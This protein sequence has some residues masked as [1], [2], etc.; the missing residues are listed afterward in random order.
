MRQTGRV[1][2]DHRARKLWLRLERS[3]KKADEVTCQKALITAHESEVK[4][5]FDADSRNP[6]FEYDEEDESHH[7]V[8]FL[9]AVTAYNQMRAASG[10][11]PAGFAVWRLGSEDPSIWSILG[12][13]TVNSPEVL[14]RIVY[15]YDV[16]FEGTGELLQVMS[17][18]QD[19]WRN[20]DI[21]QSTGFVKSEDFVSTPSS[22]VIERGGDHPGLI[23]LTFDDGPDPRWTPAILDILKKEN[24]PA[25]FFIIGKNGQSYP[26]LL[27]RIVNE[28]HEIGNHTFTHPNLGEI[29]VIVN[30]SGVERYS[31]TYR[32]GNWPVDRTVSSAVFWRRRSRQTTGSRAGIPGPATGLPDG[33]SA[34]R[35]RRLA[36]SR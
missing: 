23:A 7:K 3:E 35:S 17:R 26:D 10:Y 4:V 21:D 31:A 11:K 30:R 18:P 24:V 28:G 14:R 22:Y 33:G 34:H 2:N 6:Y 13:S 15:G 27:R 5:L 8:W 36:T 25:T 16:D 20:L 1:K 32:I 9:D 29:P 19:G 12:T